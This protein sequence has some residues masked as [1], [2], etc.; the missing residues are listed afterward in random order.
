[1]VRKG[2][3]LG[4]G[5]KFEPPEPGGNG[6]SLDAIAEFKPLDNFG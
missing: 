5:R 4:Y 2:I 6:L 1:M 3:L